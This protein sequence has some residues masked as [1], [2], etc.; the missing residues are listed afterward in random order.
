ML[1]IYI[2][3]GNKLDKKEEKAKAAK[4]AK[5]KGMFTASAFEAI[6]IFIFHI[7]VLYVYTPKA[8]VLQ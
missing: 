2:F 3:I 5:I 4:K 8:G 6:R 1:T 7:D